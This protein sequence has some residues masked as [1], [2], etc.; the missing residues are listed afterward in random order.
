[1]IRQP[2][3]TVPVRAKAYATALVVLGAGAALS[4]LRSDP[5]RAWAH[6]LVAASGLV[7]VAVEPP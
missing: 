4:A 3:F 5:Q 7:P 6:L 2:Q 1:M